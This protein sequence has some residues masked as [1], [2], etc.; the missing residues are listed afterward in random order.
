MTALALSVISQYGGH[1]CCKRDSITAIETAKRHFG[2]FDNARESKYVCSQFVYN[3]M[4]LK[5]ACPY[6]P[7]NKTRA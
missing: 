5:D 6:Y 4:C 2:Y 1:R 7:L 3:D